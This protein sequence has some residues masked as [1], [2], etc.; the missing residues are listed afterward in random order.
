[1]ALG[2]R[3]ILGRMGVVRRLSHFEDPSLQPYFIVAAFGSFLIALGILSFIIQ[4]YVSILRRRQYAVGGD[5]WDG[6]TLEWSTTSPPP[7]Y[8]F[9]FIPI[10]HERDAWTDMKA[11]GY[12]RPQAGFNAIHMPKNTATGV[13]IGALSFACCFGLVWY[14]WWLAALSLVGIIAVAIAH[15]FNY[16]Q[17]HHIP[18]DEVHRSE[19]AGNWQTDAEGAS[20]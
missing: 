20:A 8:N 19:Q 10:V 17:D 4:I 18:A 13:V 3:Y 16:H 5:P 12:E 6:R 11:H 7:E 14:I 9:A 2:P 1:V 15:T